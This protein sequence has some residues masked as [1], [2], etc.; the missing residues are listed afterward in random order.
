M[1]VDM[2]AHDEMSLG[3]WVADQIREGERYELSNGH[4]IE[5]SP[6]GGRGSRATGAGFKVIETDPDNADV[7]VD[8]GF[9][10]FPGVLRAPDIAAGRIPDEPGWVA[11]V[12]RL[13]VEYADTGQ[14]EQ[15]LARK[16][17]DLLGSGT[18]LIWVV[19]LGGPR[20]VE[21]HMPGK[22]MRLVGPGAQL[23]AP[24][25]LRNPVP[26]EALYDREISNDA[27]LR[28]LLQRKGFADL[29]EVQDRASAEGEARG[30]AKG[31]AR[32]TAALRKAIIKVLSARELTVTAEVRNAVDQCDD[33][34]TLE[35]W[36]GQA[37]RVSS[38]NEA[39]DS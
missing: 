15:G 23:R 6:V 35:R 18:E 1:L 26:V 13:A 8:T 9:T 29:Q 2:E 10:P 5:C 22:R 24:G 4:R 17:R 16:I 33:L 38:A 31:E 28:N 19:R 7:G 21:V 30:E 39:V 12:P 36:L 25:I 27:T 32:A 37:A 3:P 20:R 34:E 11:G 14:D